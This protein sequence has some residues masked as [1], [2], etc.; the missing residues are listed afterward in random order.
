MK[1]IVFFSTFIGLL[2]PSVLNAEVTLITCKTSQER[3]KSTRSW[4]DINK[5]KFSEWRKIKG[6]VYNFELNEKDN[7]IHVYF[8]NKSFDR[9]TNLVSFRPDLIKFELPKKENI[10][11]RDYTLDNYEINRI[12]G[13]FSR[14][15]KIFNSESNALTYEMQVKGK[16]KKSNLKTLF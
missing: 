2:L 13:N 6:F 14:I 8:P 1:R 11:D 5:A 10:I 16:C 15:F 4:I 7:Y 3:I 12:N 9:G